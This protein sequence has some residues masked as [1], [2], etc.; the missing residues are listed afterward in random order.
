MSDFDSN[1]KLWIELMTSGNR[2]E[3]QEVYWSK[4]FPEVEKL[5]MKK[6]KHKVES[7]EIP[8]YDSLILPMGLEAYY[9]VLLIKALKPMQVHFICTKEGERLVLDRVIRETGLKQNQY[10]KDVVEYGG[11]DVAD[12]YDKI[13]KRLD[14]LGEK[15]AVDLTFGKRVMSVGAGIVGAFFGCDLIYLD[16]GWIEEIRQED[17]GTE[18]IVI[19]KNPFYVFG[20]L[21]RVEAVDMFNKNEFE[22]ARVA[23][24]SLCSEV[25]DPRECEVRALLA[26]A[27]IF[28]D[29][30]NYRAALK[31]MEGFVCKLKQYNIRDIERNKANR[32][33]TV[34]GYLERIQNNKG[35]LIDTLKD[36]HQILHVMIDLYCNAMR[37]KEQGRIEDSVNR[38]YRILELMSQQRL[39]KIGINTG[40]P[41]YKKF[42]EEVI[43]GY[44]KL[45]DKLYMAKLVNPLYKPR[46]GF[47]REIGVKDGHLFLFVMGDPIWKGKNVNDVKKFFECLRIRDNSIVAHGIQII[48]HNSFDKLD[49]LV[50]SMLNE[51]CKMQKRDLKEMLEHHTFMKLK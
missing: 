51:M 13:K 3:A 34:L 30:F 48:S 12:V 33:L 5:F 4:I 36:E 25:S 31:K 37:R 38:F 46:E 16:G 20:D 2:K 21:K 9:Y 14:T 19:V 17:P 27:Y 1:K 24:N 28:W 26:E 8:R 49:R 47:P 18:E 7:G 35:K 50:R 22:S 40:S 45:V 29:S 6:T 23:F 43:D 44:K 10:T 15:I 32:N 39:S 42:G 11:M 41:D